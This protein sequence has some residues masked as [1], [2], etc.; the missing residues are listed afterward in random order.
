MLE[1]LTPLAGLMWAGL[2]ALPWRPYSTRERLSATASAAPQAYPD[3]TVLSPARNEAESIQTVLLGV[4][5]QG[6]LARIILVDDQSDDGTAGLANALDLDNLTIITGTTPPP[7]W[8]GKLWALQQGLAH[9]ETDKI[10]LLDADIELKPGMLKALHDHMEDLNLT[11]VSLMANLSMLSFWERLL[12]PAFVYFFKLIYPF[13]LANSN[14]SRLAAAAGGCILIQRKA[15]NDIGGFSAL[16]DAII[17]DCTLAK[18]VKENG[19]TIWLGLT[20]GAVAVRGYS[21]LSEIWDMVARTAYTQLHYSTM[22]L[23]VCTALMTVSFWVPIA[24]LLGGGAALRYI[25]L[26]ALALCFASYWPV[27]KYYRLPAFWT[28]TLPLAG[29]LFLAMTWTSAWRYWRGERSRWK[30]R[31]YSTE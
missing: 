21:A 20:D 2:L 7:G 11:M 27:I 17:D 25:A 4:A 13:A 22:L 16:H 3:V 18:Y 15:L 24:A 6:S 10:L 9:A 23:L 1:I 31:S 19:G 30:A 14:R 12:I 29:T 26:L 8:S 5:A 28:F